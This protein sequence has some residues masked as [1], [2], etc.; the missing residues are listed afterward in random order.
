[1]PENTAITIILSGI[2]GL[3]L[4]VLFLIILIFFNTWL[5]A[6][7][8]KAP[9]SVANIVAM[10]LR[11]APFSLIVDARITASKAGIELSTDELESHYL[12][13]GN[14]LP[15]VRAMADKNLSW[16]QACA[17]DLSIKR[18]HEDGNPK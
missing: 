14:L 6:L 3:V 2:G 11:G 18:P 13:K 1:M 9:V 10:R 17:L 12:A 16:E 8:A 4:L 5:K 7:L 15:T